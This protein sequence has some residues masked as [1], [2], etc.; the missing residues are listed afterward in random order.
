MKVVLVTHDSVFGRYLAAMLYAA[1]AVDQVLIEHARPS[2]RFYW[3]KLRRVGPIDFAFQVW[4]ARWYRRDG[5]RH[6]PDLAMPP[7]ERITNAND[8]GFD[9]DSLVIG[10]GTSFIA[11]STLA[12]LPNGFLNL[13]TGFLPEYRGVKSEFWPLVRGDLSHIGWTLHYMTPTLDA[14]DIVVRQRVPWD[15]ESPAALRAKLLRDAAPTIA[16]ILRSPALPRT[17]QGGGT[18]YTTPRWADWRRYRRQCSTPSEALLRMRK[19]L[20]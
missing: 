14:G 1:S 2:W 12:R 20:P 19:E 13:H 11:E 8:Y 7:H 5:G 16:R 4:L 18:Y 3:R 10:F 9:A 15:G 6:L 17:P